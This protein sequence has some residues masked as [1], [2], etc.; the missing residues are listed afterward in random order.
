MRRSFS[1]MKPR[2]IFD[3]TLLMFS[4]RMNPHNP[5][6]TSQAISILDKIIKAEDIG[7]EFGSGR[8][9]LWLAKRLAHLT[10]VESNDDWFAKVDNDIKQ[11]DVRHKIDYFLIKDQQKY[12]D[13]AS[14]FADNSLD[15]CLVDGINRDNCALNLLNKLKIGG[16]LVIDNINVYFP[17]KNIRS[18]NSRSIEDGYYSEKWEKFS[19]ETRHWRRIWTSNGVFDTC[20]FLKT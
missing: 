4:E 11:S 6:L 2:Y 10:S 3:R 9:T 14:N 15:F 17:Q 12:A 20:I 19:F 16:I 7:A 8:S 18:P 13:F 5:W 1:H